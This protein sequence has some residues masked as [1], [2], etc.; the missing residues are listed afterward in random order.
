MQEKSMVSKESLTSIRKCQRWMKNRNSRLVVITFICLFMI[1]TSLVKSETIIDNKEE[2]IIQAPAP[3]KILRSTPT[4]ISSD[5]EES[6][7][8]D[9]IVPFDAEREVANHKIDR[10][11][12]KRD[13]EV[14][15][16]T[17]DTP[18][19]DTSSYS[20]VCKYTQYFYSLEWYL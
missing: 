5:G 4:A 15:E 9:L 1:P 12:K 13:T 2:V 11:K 14:S 16:S 10:Y 7:H 8:H 6:I 18:L 19:K 17:P 20:S 3:A